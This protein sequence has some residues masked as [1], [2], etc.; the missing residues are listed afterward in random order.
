MRQ[1]ECF[2]V[3]LYPKVTRQVLFIYLL[4]QHPLFRGHATSYQ[5]ILRENYQHLL[6]AQILTDD[7]KVDPYQ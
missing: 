1:H 6:K 3:P 7:C 2:S 4:Q 5:G